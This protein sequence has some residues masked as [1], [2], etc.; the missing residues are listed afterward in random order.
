MWVGGT[1]CC[2]IADAVVGC[3]V[4][5]MHSTTTN[6]R[7]CWSSNVLLVYPRV[8]LCCFL[9]HWQA[10]IKVQTRGVVTMTHRWRHALV[11]PAFTSSVACW[12]LMSV[13]R[14][15]VDFVEMSW[16]S[17]QGE[18]TKEAEEDPGRERERWGGW[19]TADL[20][21]VWWNLSR[22]FPSAVLYLTDGQ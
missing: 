12:T 14:S 8:I 6:V 11:G 21:P 4:N 2:R 16:R 22:Y 15:C 18:K 7:Y 9:S 5:S 1:V 19:S 20:C 10:N 13:A 17:R 3:C